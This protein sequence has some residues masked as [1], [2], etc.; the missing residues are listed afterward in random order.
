MKK[1]FPAIAALFAAL[2]ACAYDSVQITYRGH[3]K[4]NS[5]AEMP[6]ETPM[7]FNVYAGKTDTEPSWT[8]TFDSVRL[9]TNGFFQVALS[10]NGLAEVISGGRAAFIGVSVDG[11]NE[12]YPRQELLRSGWAEKSEFAGALMP[13]PAVG[14][15]NVN[16]A[17]FKSL[18]AAS[19]TVGGDVSL[20]ESEQMLKTEVIHSGR[21]F[22]LK[23]RGDVTLFRKGYPI[24][25]GT[26]ASGGDGAVSF[27]VSPFNCAAF[28]TTPG[29]IVMPG[30]TRMIK[31][32]EEI[33]VPPE[34]RLPSGISVSCWVF[35]FG[36][37]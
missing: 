29:S 11:G 1:I 22:P 6:L 5:P 17:E 9:S 30:I 8:A 28:F 21:N 34:F 7:T 37:E 12:Q 31:T 36:A 2:T 23:T 20:P 24:Y 26:A 15:A 18:S 16:S 35:P 3:L 25:K 13:S 14:R 10:G 33:A 4:Y 32:G 27:G 19:I